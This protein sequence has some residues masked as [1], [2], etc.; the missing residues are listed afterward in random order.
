MTMHRHRAVARP[1]R[2]TGGLLGDKVFTIAIRELQGDGQARWRGQVLTEAA[3]HREGGDS[4]LG[5]SVRLRRWRSGGPLRL[6]QVPEATRGDGGGEANGRAVGKRLVAVLTGEVESAAMLI[7]DIDGADTL[8][9]AILDK[10]TRGWSG[11]SHEL[12]ARRKVERGRKGVTL[13]LSTF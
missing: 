7:F 11:A 10:R 4:K 3:Q 2:L 1:V 13:A 8:P 6:R 9:M 12:L 5:D